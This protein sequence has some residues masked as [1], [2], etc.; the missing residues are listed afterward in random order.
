MEDVNENEERLCECGECRYCD[1]YL[2]S[3]YDLEG[4]GF[5][6]SACNGGGCFYCEE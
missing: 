2:L 1:A 4:E 3:E 5:V 6:C